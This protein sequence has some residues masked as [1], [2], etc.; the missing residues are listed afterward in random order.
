MTASLQSWLATNPQTA[1]IA[2]DGERARRS[3]R[4]FIEGG[5]H[6]LEPTNPF[7]PGWH[8]DAIAEHLEAVTR[9]DIRNLVINM[10]P[11]HAKSLLVSVF[12]PMWE[13]ASHP[14]RRWLFSS[15]AQSLSIRD[16]LKCRR[17]IQSP[18]Y[19]MRWGHLFGLTGDQNAKTRFDNDRTGYRLATSVGGVGTGEGGDR[20]VVDDP[21][22]VLEAESDAV[23][24]GT[25]IWWD[26]TMSS[27]GNDPKTVAKVIVMQRVHDA[28]LSGHT[29]AQ[30]GYEHLCL[31][32][33]YEAGEKRVTTIGWSDPR[34]EE[35]E[36]LCPDRFG[37]PE[38]AELEKRLGSVAAAGQLQQRPMPRGGQMFQRHWF[39]IVPA[40]APDFYSALVRYWDKAGTQGGGAYTAGVLMGKGRDGKFYVVSVVREQV[41]A[42]PRRALIKQ[43]AASDRATYGGRVA[44]WQEQEPGSGGK[45]QAET[46]VLD[47]A[48]YSVHTERVTGDKETRAVPLASQA[49]GGAG[50]GNLKVVQ[51]EWNEKW[52]AEMAGFPRGKY[53]DQVDASSGAFNKLNLPETGKATGINPLDFMTSIKRH[54]SPRR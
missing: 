28:D 8:I 43:T 50:Y 45:E 40:P 25:L 13:W 15:Y 23:R 5:W 7:V 51:A 39:E 21:H 46:Q 36:L 18:W 24:E 20:I 19:Q 14:E 41:E 26:E 17:L 34:T 53:K 10:P 32:A 49:F 35:G 52:L 48:G 44:I 1:R 42:G 33:R 2:I 47:L 16:S 27:R 3:L 54:S 4:H 6:V 22:N 11:R 30:G 31:P 38:L 12:W 29:L 37:E 9:G